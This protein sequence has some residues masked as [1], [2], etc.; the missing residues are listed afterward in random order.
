ML[1][2]TILKERMYLLM[3]CATEYTGLLTNMLGKIIPFLGKKKNKFSFK[4]K[5]SPVRDWRSTPT[6]CQLQSHVTHKLG[7]N[8]K[9]RPR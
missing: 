8:L 3:H 7:Q 1:L 9:I 4:I 2:H 5:I 6:Y